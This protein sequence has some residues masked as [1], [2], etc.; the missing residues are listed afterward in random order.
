MESFSSI[1]V[2]IEY[3]R[4][5]KDQWIQNLFSVY[6][7]LKKVILYLLPAGTFCE[8]WPILFTVFFG[9][10]QPLASIEMIIISM[11]TD[12]VASMSLIK[13]KPEADLLLRMPRRPEKDKLANFKLLFQAYCFIGIPMLVCASA[14]AFRVFSQAGIP[15]SSLWLSF[16]NVQVNGVPVDPVLYQDTLYR[17]QSVY[18]VTLVLM[19]WGNLLMTRTRR[20]SIFQQPPIG[21]KSTRNLYIFMAMGFTLSILVLFIFIPFFQNVFHTRDVYVE[22]WFIRTTLFWLKLTIAL[23]FGVGLLLMDETRKAIVRRWP[24]GIVARF[25]W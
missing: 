25:A 11:L 4:L 10:P 23:G 13:E 14:M 24:K 16:G 12:C 21:P 7:N 6:D 5:G 22:Y 18:F 3:G 1:V 15:F 19:Q 9:L 17:A 8:L 20:L 2:C